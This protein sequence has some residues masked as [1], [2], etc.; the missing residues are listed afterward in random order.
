[1]FTGCQKKDI[2]IGDNTASAEIEKTK[3]Y[4]DAYN[5]GK[6]IS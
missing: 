6:S 1:M 3:A 4:Q 5:L 2:I